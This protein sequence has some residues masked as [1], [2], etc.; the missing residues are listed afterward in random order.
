MKRPPSRAVVEKLA[1]S[2][3]RGGARTRKPTSHAIRD[4]EIASALSRNELVLHYQPIVDLR[5]GECRR[6]EAL[7]RWRHPRL[8]L[9]EPGDFL[10]FASELIEQIGVWVVR[11]ATAQW[12]Q[13]RGLGP[14]LGVGINVSAP[15]LA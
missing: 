11:A 10:P 6:V 7:L 5:S 2:D 15:E 3:A 9:L 12:T 8:G 13:W 1:R 14:A 4:G